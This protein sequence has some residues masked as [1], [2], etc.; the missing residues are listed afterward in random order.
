MLLLLLLMMLMHVT[1]GG[2]HV[3]AQLLTPQSTMGEDAGH[4]G[5]HRSAIGDERTGS[6]GG[7]LLVE[8]VHWIGPLDYLGLD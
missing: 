7:L 3:A 6:A 1:G 4:L 2:W 5:T 8:L